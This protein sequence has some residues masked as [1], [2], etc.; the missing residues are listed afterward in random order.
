ME[1]GRERASQGGK[2]SEGKRK[3]EG[4]EPI[5]QLDGRV[6]DSSLL[7]SRVVFFVTHTLVR[8]HTFS[9]LSIHLT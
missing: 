3:K 1:G 6:T 4:K 2:E 7:L 8:T 9:F 5:N